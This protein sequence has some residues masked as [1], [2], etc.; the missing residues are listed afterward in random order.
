M[1]L[2]EAGCAP[3]PDAPVPKWRNILWTDY[4]DDAM[5]PIK[6][7][8]SI[9]LHTKGRA[10][11]STVRS[12]ASLMVYTVMTWT[13]VPGKPPTVS[14]TTPVGLRNFWTGG[15]L[16]TQESMWSPSIRTKQFS[17]TTC[18]SSPAQV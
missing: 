5:W 9:S 16:R 4:L 14:P 17:C 6:I 10:L 18:M 13:N 2:T 1:C 7:R 15:P 12:I 8:S 3:D 11:T